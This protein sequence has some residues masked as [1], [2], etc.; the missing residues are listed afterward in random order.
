MQSQSYASKT[1]P[2]KRIRSL[3]T[4]LSVSIF[5]VVSLVFAVF[6]VGISYS[7]S[8]LIEGRAGAEV[9]EKTKLVVNLIE[10]SDKDLRKRIGVLA[11]SFQGSLKG[12]FTVG[13]ELV[14]IQGKPTPSLKLDGRVL[15]LDFSGVDH[16]FELTGAVPTVFVKSGD[17]FVRVTTAVRN[18]KGERMVGTMLDR[19]HPGYKAVLAG[20][21]YTGVAKLFGRQY[22]TQYDP[23]KSADG[24]IIGLSFVGID[25]SESLNE[26]KVAI[27]NAKIGQS[28]YFYVLDGSAG[29]NY[30]NLL[31][32]PVAEGK[33]MLASKDANGREFIK[34]LLERKSGSIR[35]PWINKELGESEPRD[36]V[37]AFLP[38]DSWQWVVVG[39]VYSDEFSAEM[40]TLRNGYALMGLVMVFCISGA[41]FVFI[42]RVVSVP[43]GE[44]TQAAQSLAQGDLTVHLKDGRDDEIGQLMQA[45][46]QVGSSLEKVV[47]H[48]RLCSDGLATASAEIAQGNQ[49]LSGRTAS[50]AS[51]LEQTAAS[52]EQLGAAVKHNADSALTANQLAVSASAVAVQG[53]EVVAQVVETMKHIN[54]SSKRIFD[55][56]S[57]IDGIA[58]QTN[59][60]A[61]N[62]AVEA[63]RA[64]EQGRGFA[65][66]ASEVR[67]LAG[68]SAEAAKEIK[69]LISASVDRVALGT[70]LVDQAGST[71]TEVVSSIRRVTDIMGEISAASREQAAG[72][73]QVGEAV[74]NM[75][76]VTQQNAALVEEMAAAANS[77]KGQAQELVQTVAVFKLAGGDLGA[78]HVLRLSN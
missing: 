64:G 35:Y 11:K 2:F 28:G 65:V 39:S 71:M 61:L 44:V 58:F 75:D 20:T 33:N 23:I 55:I 7:T 66:V 43:L 9:A 67:S 1:P 36:K 74:T 27:R 37:A 24:K 52:M 45:M 42:R 53:G 57:V 10:S 8:Q 32:H 46:N 50:Q 16:F 31:I 40:R 78:G 6:I 54:D 51:A 15:N 68:R 25:F 19:A 3:G 72:V 5:S 29:A 14:D 18:E 4:K 41:L 12:Q 62:A 48:A 26:I 73:T 47:A 30:G 69:N 49:D 22:I 70:T 63:A 77:L 76:H 59:I 34:E 13:S 60:L 21:T 56:I 38:V 17:D